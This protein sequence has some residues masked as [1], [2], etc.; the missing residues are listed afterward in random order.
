METKNHPVKQELYSLRRQKLIIQ[1][2]CCHRN[3]HV[4]GIPLITCSL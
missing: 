4:S 3:P 2:K 1:M